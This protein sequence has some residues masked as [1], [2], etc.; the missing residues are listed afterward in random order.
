MCNGESITILPH[1]G[2]HVPIRPSRRAT[3]WRVQA[4][5]SFRGA[6]RHFDTHD[7]LLPRK[8]SGWHLIRCYCFV[9]IVSWRKARYD[10][11]CYLWEIVTKHHTQ[12]EYC[13][14]QRKECP[15]LEANKILSMQLFHSFY[16]HTT[17]FKIY[18]SYSLKWYWLKH[19]IVLLLLDRKGHSCLFLLST[20]GFIGLKYGVRSIDTSCMIEQCVI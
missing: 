14:I 15:W 11:R 13:P 7:M 16:Y 2:P 8:N 1:S 12:P 5:S 4:R 20:A 10:M 18:P 19:Q 6:Q 3:M 17:I 9:R